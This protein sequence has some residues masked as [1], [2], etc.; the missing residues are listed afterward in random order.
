MSNQSIR[1]QGSHNDF[2]SFAINPASPR[3]VFY[4]FSYT[5]THL[6]I[7][8]M[9]QPSSRKRNS[10]A[11]A[12]MSPMFFQKHE[13]GKTVTTKSFVKLELPYPQE[14]PWE[15]S[16]PSKLSIWWC[17]L[18]KSKENILSWSTEQD[19]FSD[20]IFDEHL[21]QTQCILAIFCRWLEQ[22]LTREWPATEVRELQEHD[23][24]N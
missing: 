20:F 9:A 2:S 17:P 10:N 12:L 18:F 24:L 19:N 1:W 4:C 21:S 15:V 23:P 14:K 5:A 16:W 6:A 7:S 11:Y 22:K 8:S 3:S 13:R